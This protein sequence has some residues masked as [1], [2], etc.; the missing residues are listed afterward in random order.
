[1]IRPIAMSEAHLECRDIAR[2]QPVHTDL[3]GFECVATSA[4][5][6]TMRHPNTPWLLVLHG[7]AGTA[8]KPF[9]HHTGV[10]VEHAPEIDAAYEYLDENR[11][12]YGLTTITKPEFSHG[13][14]SVY[15]GEP[16][17]NR[18]EIE[19]YEAVLRKESGGQRLGGVRSRHWDQA[20]SVDAT[21]RG[22]APLAFTHGTLHTNSTEVCDRFARE[23]LGLET[24]Q[25]YSHV[26]YVKH[27]ETKHFIV[28]LE[29]L[30]DQNRE[31]DNFRFT[32]QVASPTEVSDAHA[33]LSRDGSAVGV[34]ALG[35]LR[36]DDAG[37][38]F[39]LRDPD[40]NCWEITS[41]APA[42]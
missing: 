8:D 3:L 16:G 5:Q 17:G 20:G 10:R 42:E 13:S 40:N 35:A 29:H 22:Y 33:W 12:R 18:W 11:E 31:S 2:S 37:Y 14:Y 39:V 26:L 6:A 21:N 15:L 7:A 38:S 1:M 25:A 32:L 28:C 19:C 23:V 9:A 24:H 41:R 27:P 30:G 4:D 36:Q 34:Q